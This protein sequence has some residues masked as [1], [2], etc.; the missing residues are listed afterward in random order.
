MEESGR[1]D[2][3]YSERGGKD[4]VKQAKCQKQFQNANIS[5][6]LLCQAGCER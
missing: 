4:T 5:P 3:I 6:I 2:I 1:E